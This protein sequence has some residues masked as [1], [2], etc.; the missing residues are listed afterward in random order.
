MDGMPVE[1]EASAGSIAGNDLSFDIAPS[2]VYSQL[3]RGALRP[4]MYLSLV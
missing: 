1:T 2:I 4:L 3:R